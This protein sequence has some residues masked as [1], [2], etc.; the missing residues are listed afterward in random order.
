MNEESSN[1]SKIRFLMHPKSHS[2]PIIM[3]KFLVKEKGSIQYDSPPHIKEINQLP[4][5]DLALIVTFPAF[6]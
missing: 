5:H 4:I 3:N 2:R 6:S 1:G